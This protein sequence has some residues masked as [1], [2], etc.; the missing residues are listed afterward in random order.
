MTK[1]IPKNF[2]HFSP[3]KKREA[4]TLDLPLEPLDP[5]TLD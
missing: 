4:Q 1:A 3:W 2:M 5:Q